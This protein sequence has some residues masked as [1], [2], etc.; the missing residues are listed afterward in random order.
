MGLD[1]TIISNH[2]FSN[3]LQSLKDVIL[4]KMNFEYRDSD[5]SEYFWSVTKDESYR[6][7]R[8]NSWKFNFMG[9]SSLKEVVQ[10]DNCI[11]FKGPWA[12]IMRFGRNSYHLDFNLRWNHFLEND[13]IQTRIFAL[14]EKMNHVFPSKFNIFIPDNETKSSGFSDLVTQNFSLEQILNKMIDGIGK[15]CASIDEL[16]SQFEIDENAYLK[17]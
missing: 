6:E 14:M 11:C 4:E 12:I 5:L 3:D 8:K 13:L 9:L 1:L 7:W 2:E 15:P 10:K 17:K 16:V